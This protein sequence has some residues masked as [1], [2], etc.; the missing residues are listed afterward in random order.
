MNVNYISLYI[1][2][3]AL[4]REELKSD[5][6]VQ[7]LQILLIVSQYPGIGMT[8]LGKLLELSPASISRNVA[9]LSEQSW[10]K[11]PGP[12]GRMTPQSGLGLL[13]ADED[14]YNRRFKMVTLTAKGLHVINNIRRVFSRHLDGRDSRVPHVSN[15]V[16]GQLG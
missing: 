5:L 8:E 1:E 3:L 11:K 2:L 15:Q 6:P 12:N 13:R 16:S 4:A 14:P 10:I 7:T 9:E